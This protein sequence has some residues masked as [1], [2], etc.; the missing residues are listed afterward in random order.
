MPGRR[1]VLKQL[2][3]GIAIQA[4]SGM[5]ARQVFAAGAA[6][7]LSQVT[8]NTVLLSGL[9]GNVVALS[10]PDGHNIEAVWYDPSKEK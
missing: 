2:A 9:G 1:Q 8:P 6:P 4:L 3:G 5:A 10:T 7:T